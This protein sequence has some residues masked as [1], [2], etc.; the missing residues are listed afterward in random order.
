M[1]AAGPHLSL[2]SWSPLFQAVGALG[3]AALLPL[4]PSSVDCEGG[5][6]AG[7]GGTREDWEGVLEDSVDNREEGDRDDDDLWAA[8][9]AVWEFTFLQVKKLKVA[10]CKH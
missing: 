5:G 9:N 3:P 8:L 2:K 10:C 7:V 4:S 1:A 6:G